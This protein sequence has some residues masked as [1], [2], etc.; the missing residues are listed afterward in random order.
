MRIESPMT[1]GG[2]FWR[3]PPVSAHARTMRDF[4]CILIIF[5]TFFVHQSFAD[6]ADSSAIHFLFAVAIAIAALVAGLQAAA[7]LG[8]LAAPAAL[9][10][11]RI[12]GGTA[13]EA[14]SFGLFAFSAIL[15]LAVAAHLA[16]L[17][18]Q[19][20]QRQT[21]AAA[22]SISR[23]EIDAREQMLLSI[24]ATIPV[25]MVIIDD[26]GQIR[27]FSRAAQRLFGYSEAEAI[28][29]NVSLLM[30]CY[31]RATHDD[32]L[33]QFRSAGEPKKIAAGRR[34]I[35]QCKDGTTVPLEITMGEAMCGQR[36]VFTGFLHDLTAR[37]KNAARVRELQSELLHISRVS[38][39]GTMAS[40]LAHELNQPL[41]AVTNY[42]QTSQALLEAPDAGTMALARAALVEAGG[43]AL[44]AGH[45]VR[46][47]REFVA[48]G[49]TIKTLEPIDE[50]IED[51]CLLSLAGAPEQGITRRLSLDTAL[52]PIL[53]DRVQ[54]QQVLINLVRNAVEAMV[55]SGGGRV[56]IIVRN[57]GEYARITIADTGPGLAPEVFDMLFQAFVSTKRE[58]MGLGLS[59]CRTIVEAHG[60]KIWAERAANGGA[61]FHFTVPR[62]LTEEIHG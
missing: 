53:I 32:F 13:R 49:E 41:T 27:S 6:P 39:I 30:T 3:L 45:I 20:A 26:H 44:R 59:I 61:A 42:V 4:F 28:G 52:G 25:A 24:L 2:G 46:R 18:Y 29:Q 21:E 54:I 37:Q 15:I 50:L 38:A 16:T 7:F 40:A 43:E 47:L 12:N 9:L 51:T 5:V 31:D 1:P 8:L 22:Q 17:S 33:G 11:L 62:A 48:R 57:E 56:D 36:R 14:L 23:A 58:G 19:I 10:F 60:G 35:G 55:P 34:V